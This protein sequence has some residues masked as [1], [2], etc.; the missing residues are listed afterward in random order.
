MEMLA[1]GNHALNDAMALYVSGASSESVVDTSFVGRIA[2]AIGQH[3]VWKAKLLHAAHTGEAPWDPSTVELDDRC[4]FGTW[5]YQ[6]IADHERDGHWERV[7]GLHAEFHREAARILRL[8]V[9][10]Q[11]RAAEEQMSIGTPYDGLTTELVLAL[12]DWREDRSH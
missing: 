5:L 10:G 3:G 12:D 8:A 2:G 4:V 1:G 6:E 7:R 11:G 9:S